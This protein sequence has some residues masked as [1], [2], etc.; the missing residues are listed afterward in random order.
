MKLKKLIC[1]LR[2]LDSVMNI[3]VK[4]IVYSTR[5]LEVAGYS[6]LRFTQFVVVMTLLSCGL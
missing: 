2:L 4:W 6:H 1:S 3:V 5:D